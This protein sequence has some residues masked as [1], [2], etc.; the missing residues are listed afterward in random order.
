METLTQPT[1][2][3]VFP[4][5]RPPR[6]PAPEVLD[7]IREYMA[8]QR[9]RAEEPPPEL[10]SRLESGRAP[11]FRDTL[12]SMIRS[13]GLIDSRVCAAAGVDRRHFSKIR[14]SSG[15]HPTKATALSFAF[16]LRLGPRDAA[17]LLR[18]AGYALSDS[19]DFDLI[20]SYFLERGEWDANA[21][22]D[23]LYAYGQPLICGAME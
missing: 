8:L 19:S 11:S 18:T 12:L 1:D 5:R 4:P 21:V 7:A 14:N 20:C 3:T 13:R 22:N 2:G 10:A 9:I 17:R 16:A 6:Q 15:Y 23:A